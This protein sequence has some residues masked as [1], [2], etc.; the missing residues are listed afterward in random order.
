[1]AAYDLFAHMDLTVNH[2]ANPDDEDINKGV[3]Q[4]MMGIVARMIANDND[5][6]QD[7]FLDPSE[8]KV[9]CNAL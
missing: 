3:A 2:P 5:E 7:E 6:A 8:I 9:V 4:K 1:M